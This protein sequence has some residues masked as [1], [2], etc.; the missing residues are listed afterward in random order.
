MS[1]QQPLESYPITDTFI[2][3]H[4]AGDGPARIQAGPE[5][6]VGRIV[7][8]GHR[9]IRRPRGKEEEAG[10]PAEADLVRRSAGCWT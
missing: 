8:G 6:H 5:A 9:H 7:S 2:F 4:V 1:N 10:E 3:H